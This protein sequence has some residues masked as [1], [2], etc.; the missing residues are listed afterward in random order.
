MVDI[1][2]KQVRFVGGESYIPNSRTHSD[3]DVASTLI[4]FHWAIEW[5]T[6]GYGSRNHRENMRLR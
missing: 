3:I 2:E 1:P 6:V 4:G 5:V